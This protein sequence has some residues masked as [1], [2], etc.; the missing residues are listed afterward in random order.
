MVE[1]EV[2]K[3]NLYENMFKSIKTKKIQAG[4]HCNE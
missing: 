2:V 3:S 1:E 4:K